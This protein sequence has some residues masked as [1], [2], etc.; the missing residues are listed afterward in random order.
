MD[1]LAGQKRRFEFENGRSVQPN[2]PSMLC[3]PLM[4]PFF[5]SFCYRLIRVSSFETVAKLGKLW[6]LYFIPKLWNNKV[7]LIC[8]A[9]VFRV[10]N[11]SRMNAFMC[12][13]MLCCT[14]NIEWG[15]WGRDIE[16]GRGFFERQYF[17]GVLILHG[18]YDINTLT[19]INVL[20]WKE[21]SQL[22]LSEIAARQCVDEVH[23]FCFILSLFL[24]P[25]VVLNAGYLP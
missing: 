13:L 2:D 16:W 1:R 25:R 4:D 6:S 9:S 15:E 3:D 14:D 21:V 19:I 20:S 8:C 17:L 10:G 5:Y 24:V 11:A 18:H 7:F 23:C 12:F 22:L